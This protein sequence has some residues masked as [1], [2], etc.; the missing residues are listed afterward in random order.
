MLTLHRSD[1]IAVALVEAIQAG[2]VESL[3][4]LLAQNPGLASAR[5]TDSN[6][7]ARTP[8]HVVTDWPGYFANGPATVVTLIAAGANPNAPF[9]GGAH[10][11]TPLHWA[12]SSDDVEVAAALINGGAD[13]E[14]PGASIAGGTPLDDAVGYGCWQV[15]R[16]LVERGSRVDKLWHA[17]ALGMMSRIAAFF[18]GLTQP[19]PEEVNNAFWQACHGG[20]RR[21][22]EY[23]LAK[24]AD[25]NWMPVYADHTTPL[26]ISAA[27]DTGREA[28]V[29]WLREKGAV[30]ADAVQKTRT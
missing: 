27:L 30:S 13:L 18:E 7:G 17:A 11:E 8:L 23:F 25:L 21:A 3:Q 26:D 12:A 2:N 24:G 19:A 14:A 16:L 9:E 20:Q 10:A 6:G 28:V 29:S 5:I 15:A 22:A 1:P 4:H